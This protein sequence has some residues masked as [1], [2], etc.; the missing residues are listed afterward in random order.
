MANNFFDLFPFKKNGEGGSPPPSPLSSERGEGQALASATKSRNWKLFPL[1]VCVSTL[2]Q[3][4]A[5]RRFAHKLIKLQWILLFFLYGSLP[6]SVPSAANFGRG[7][8]YPPESFPVKQP[9]FLLAQN[10]YSLNY[11]PP[12][13]LPDF[14]WD[15][16]LLRNYPLYIVEGKGAMRV[17]LGETEKEIRLFN[18]DPVRRDY[19]SPETLYYELPEANA[20]FLLKRGRIIQIKVRLKKH[21]LPNVVWKT[22]YGLEQEKL[23]ELVKGIPQSRKTEVLKNLILSAYKNPDYIWVSPILHIYSRGIAFKIRG[24]KVEEI[25]VFPATR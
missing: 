17:L 7:L 22:A 5:N 1:R 21:S 16:R 4:L 2:A 24:G 9:T 15:K 11:V 18:G 12:W 10:R 3:T 13:N 6:S 20:E 8:R 19:F 25:T 23:Q 14:A